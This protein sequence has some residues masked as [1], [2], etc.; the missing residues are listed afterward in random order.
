MLKDSISISISHHA[1]Q[2]MYER[3]G[4]S[5]PSEQRKIVEKAYRCGRKKVSFSGD[6][7]R[8]LLSKQADGPHYSIRVFSNCVF[9]FDTT[10]QKGC[11]QLLTVYPIPEE[12]FPLSQWEN[13]GGGKVI[14]CVKSINSD[15][16]GCSYLYISPEGELV[17]DIALALSFKTE[18][19]ARNY[20]QNNNIFKGAELRN[21]EI[22]FIPV[23]L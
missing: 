2:R 17:E 19:R 6:F 18:Q 11:V 22:M 16:N 23:W 10:I 9:I 15:T 12:Y 7:Y 4:I 13:Y 8:F 5:L 3:L 21:E 20:V 1:A 14:I